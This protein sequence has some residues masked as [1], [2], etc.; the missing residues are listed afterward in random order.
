MPK[1]R[2]GIYAAAVTPFDDQGGVDAA[3]LIAYCRHLVTD[4]GCDGIAPTGTT[5]EGNSISAKDRLALPAAFAAAGF[6]ADQVIFGTGACS[7]EDAIAYTRASLDAGFANVLILPPFYYKNP[8]DDGLYAYY[9][10]IIDKVNSDALRIYLYHFPQM[11]MT[12][13]SPALVSRLKAEFGPIIAGLKDSSGDFSQ[14]LAFV[15]ATGGIDRDFDVY[16][17]SEAMVFDALEAKCAGIISGSTNAFGNLVRAALNADEAGR[18]QAFQHVKAARAAAAKY[19]LMAGMKQLEAWRTNDES[20]TRMAPP[21]VRLNEAQKTGLRADL[22]TL[23]A[24][25]NAAQ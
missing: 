5:G 20:W 14:S 12:P 4:G 22:D 3:K 6:A 19:P 18:E 11:S 1:A 24:A 25:R 23:V 13:L 2:R 8:S 9:A 16:P 21:L 17:S 15:E 10:R 7:S